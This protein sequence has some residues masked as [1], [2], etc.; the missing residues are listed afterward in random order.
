[1]VEDYLG[2]D[3][4]CNLLKIN[5]LIMK[6]ILFL[7]VIATAISCSSDGEFTEKIKQ[8]VKTDALG[9]EMNYQSISF[10]WIDTL[11]VNKQL[12]KG[13]AAYEEMLNPL[14]DY[15]SFSEEVLNKEK[16]IELRNWENEQ[17]NTP[18]MFSG[19]KYKNYEEFAFANRDASTFISDL[20]YQIEITDKILNEW[21]NLEKGNLDLIRNAIWYYERQ[22]KYYN[23]NSKPIWKSAITLIDELEKLQAENDRLSKM[24]ANEIMEYKA[25]NNYKINNPLLNGVEV[26]VSKFFIFDKEL[27]IIRTE[28]VE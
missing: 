10:Q 20:C 3:N 22:D 11:T 26:E 8:K 14:L 21:D 17:R 28:S 7:L 5:D 4:F 13:L 18:F 25:L 1:M 9:V 23:T 24:D 2:L 12:T 19:K 6:N 16:L 27:N 15:S